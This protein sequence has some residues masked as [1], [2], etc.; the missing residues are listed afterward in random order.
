MPSMKPKQ[1]T[2]KRVSVP[3]TPALES[4]VAS[5]ARELGGS[6][7]QAARR[8][9]ER[10]LA[11]MSYSAPKYLIA[12]ANKR[13]LDRIKTASNTRAVTLGDAR[14]VAYVR[15]GKSMSA[16]WDDVHAWAV[17]VSFDPHAGRPERYSVLAIHREN[18]TFRVLGRE[19]PLEPAMR[20]AT[21][22]E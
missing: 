4:A 5:V 6:E 8:L 1:F 2:G 16:R 13:A 19:L 15:D 9:M 20:I 22:E 12:T 7:A 18:G 21:G 3:L 11:S 10:G 17:Y 14:L